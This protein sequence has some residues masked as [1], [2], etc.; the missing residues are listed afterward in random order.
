MK[1]DIRRILSLII[2]FVMLV[3]VLAA[4]NGENTP[5]ETTPPGDVTTPSDE[6]T[7]TPEETKELAPEVVD[8]D[9]Y[10]FIILAKDNE[11]WFE[12]YA[13]ETGAQTGEAISDALYTREVTLE[14]MYNC[15][16]TLVKDSKIDDKVR[17]NAGSGSGEH[18]ADA[19][20]TTG[21]S[22]LQLARAGALRNVYKIP[23][24]RLQNSYW[25]Q[26]IQKEYQ[27]G[28]A[29]YC[30]EGDINIR[31]DLRT[32]QVTVNKDLYE[33]YKLNESYGN[34]Y[35]LVRNKKWTFDTMMEMS[36]DLYED[37]DANGQSM[38]D[39]YGLLSELSGPYYFF[40]GSGLRTVKNH[41]DSLESCLEDPLLLEA[42][43]KAILLAST[44]SV[45]LVN[46]GKV[47]GMTS[48]WTDAITL[49]KN[50]QALF[51]SSALSSVNGYIDMKSDYGII[52]VPMLFNTND[53]YYC[54]VSGNNHYP[55]SIPYDGIDDISVTASIIEAM[56]YYSK[57]LE[58]D[59]YNEAFYERLADFRLG[60]TA[61]DAEMLDL[62][63]D[64]KTFELDRPLVVT[65]VESQMYNKA[66]EGYTGSFA[67]VIAGAKTT[68]KYNA[69]AIQQA[70][71]KVAAAEE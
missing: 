58:T 4:C 26:N 27:V 6:N 31:D 40:L 69:I 66:K 68:A 28:K 43:D 53:R 30:L 50:D 7:T 24:L 33:K 32:I 46:S 59:N 15:E 39:T 54:W 1:K 19:I 65:S 55:L 36:K 14:Q 49:F 34:L 56:A 51:R 64:S 47:A 67:S 23:E 62:I 10:N 11:L 25:D 2:V 22:T 60:Q 3:S 8:C 63:F 9:E 13:N 52:P 38:E 16:I 12:M 35:D 61:D 20:Y 18:I 5:A 37:P 41:N 71:D 42:L 44:P 17:L 21:S 70:F 29:L 45:C 57:Y 48:V